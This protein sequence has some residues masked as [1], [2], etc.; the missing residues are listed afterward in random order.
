MNTNATFK[1]T[2]DS[3]F[4]KENYLCDSFMLVK[5]SLKLSYSTGDHKFLKNL[6]PF[7]RGLHCGEQNYPHCTLS[8]PKHLLLRNK[9]I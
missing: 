9:I 2:K 1:C 3:C 6:F 4:S 8:L 7:L 5:S